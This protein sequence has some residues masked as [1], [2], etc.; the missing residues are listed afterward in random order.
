MILIRKKNVSTLFLLHKRELLINLFIL[1]QRIFIKHQLG[2]GLD[3]GY[4]N[5]VLPY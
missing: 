1:L 2:G 5:S 3:V 4:T